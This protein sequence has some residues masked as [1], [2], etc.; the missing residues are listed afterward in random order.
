MH[1]GDTPAAERP[2][3]V[4]ASRQAAVVVGRDYY[5]RDRHPGATASSEG[6]AW[7]DENPALPART[8][9]LQPGGTAARYETVATP[10]APLEDALAAYLAEHPPP[11]T[12]PADDRARG[13]IPGALRDQLRALGYDSDE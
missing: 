7:G 8:T 9:T 4:E 12:P 1:A 6:R 10:P 2:L 13:E 3:F 5:A 11:G